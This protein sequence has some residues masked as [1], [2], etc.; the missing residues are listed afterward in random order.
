MMCLAASGLATEDATPFTLSVTPFQA[1]DF[2]GGMKDPG[3]KSVEN[4][5]RVFNLRAVGHIIDVHCHLCQT[6]FFFLLLIGTE[7]SSTTPG[8]PPLAADGFAT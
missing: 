7:L 1:I 2:H 5:I 3:A 8:H 4:V 6:L